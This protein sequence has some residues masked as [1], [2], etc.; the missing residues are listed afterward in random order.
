MIWVE[1]R[2]EGEASRPPIIR[3][4]FRKTW[5]AIAAAALI[6]GVTLAPLA[7]ETLAPASPE[8]VWQGVPAIYGNFYTIGSELAKP[9]DIDVLVVGSSDSWTSLDPR[10]IKERL[11][12]K[13]GRP[14]RVLNLSTNWPGDERNASIVRD[15]IK[16]HKVRLVLI[17]ETDAVQTT[18]HELAKYWWRPSVST[19]GLET[20]QA[21]E[22]YLMSAIGLPRQVWA[23]FQSPETAPLMD[24][25]ANYLKEQTERLGFNAAKTGWKSHYETDE[26]KR[27]QYVDQ[28]PPAVSI[29]PE[30]LFYSGEPDDYFDVRPDYT[31]MQTFFVLTIREMV[32][33]QGGLFATFSIPT[34]FQNTPLEKAWVRNH[35]GV[36]RNWPIIGISMTNL[37]PG[38]DFE[39]MRDFYGNESHLN[40]SGARA[41]TRALLP[42]IE[43]LYADAIGS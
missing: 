2:K 1:S 36:E 31:W 35:R 19:N 39:Q 41:Y 8:K 18:P 32:T 5:H 26:S 9:G 13:Y 23:R 21:A 12:A 34:H 42:A 6:G 25:Y 10:I 29:N 20:Q 24:S 27:R 4:P 43:K 16:T 17:P 11:E 15:A 40:E 3:A 38:M 28:E 30:N 37:F 14:M 33:K 7:L 22:L